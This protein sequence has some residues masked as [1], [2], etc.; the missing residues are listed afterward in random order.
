VAKTLLTTLDPEN[1]RPENSLTA[2]GENSD[3]RKENQREKGRLRMAMPHSVF[4]GIHTR[5]DFRAFSWGCRRR[6]VYAG[7]TG[8]VI[9]ENACRVTVAT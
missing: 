5:Y 3:R 8:S 2:C 7:S 9:I 6:R 1:G 4:A